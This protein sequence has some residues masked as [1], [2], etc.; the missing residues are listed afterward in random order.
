MNIEPVTDA[1]VDGRVS[2]VP[3][4]A[5][6]HFPAGETR[7][8]LTLS[9]EMLVRSA[10]V[11]TAGQLAIS[12]ITVGK[13]VGAPGDMGFTFNH[14]NGKP[15]NSHNRAVSVSATGSDAF[16][17]LHTTDGAFADLTLAVHPS[18]AALNERNLDKLLGSK[19]LVRWREAG[20]KVTDPTW[21]L[22]RPV[23]VTSGA[24]L[25]AAGEDRKMIVCP[26]GENGITNAVSEL[27]RR[28]ATDASFL[29]GRYSAD[30]AKLVPMNGQMGLV[31][32][33]EDFNTV[34]LPLAASLKDAE[35][36]NFNEGLTIN[37]VSL[38]PPSAHA[39]TV[40]VPLKLHREPLTFDGE[41]N[42]AAPLT[43]N[44]LH[45]F[46]DPDAA[47]T[48]ATSMAVALP[49]ATQVHGENAVAL[50]T[51]TAAAPLPGSV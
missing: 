36:E 31:M 20:T 34:A 27:V 42:P 35:G 33:E 43:L 6:L 28:N 39:H 9:P 45:A 12:G 40:Q 22:M 14:G 16:H 15:I 8:S 2:V 26:Q 46:V 17:A 30:N 13:A 38:A 21:D 10:A 5:N 4:L 24:F 3:V 49:L 44:S 41:T 37:A 19:R 50:H 47:A 18:D 29:G 1:V 7:A 51:V 11:K 32:S 25:S 23:N 48:K